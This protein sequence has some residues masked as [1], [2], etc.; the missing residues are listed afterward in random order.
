MKN[1]FTILFRFYS[2]ALMLMA[3]ACIEYDR[4]MCSKQVCLKVFR[5]EY[6]D[7]GLVTIAKSNSEKVNKRPRFDDGI[8][9]RMRENDGIFASIRLLHNHVNE[10]VGLQMCK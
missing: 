2:C 9:E 10:A 5:N 4:L 6:M 7:F 1:G 8:N 3:H